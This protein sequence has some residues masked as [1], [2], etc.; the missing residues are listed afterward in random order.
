M[1]HQVDEACKAAIFPRARMRAILALAFASAFAV[2]W[3]CFTGVIGSD[4][5]GY[6]YAADLLAH[7]N[8]QPIAHHWTNRLM[9]ILPVALVYRLFGM[10]EWSTVITPL[11]AS[12]ASVPLL[13]AIGARLFSPAA[14]VIA[15]VLLMTFPVHVRYASV[16]VPEPVTEFLLLLGAWA[17]LRAGEQS[18]GWLY[19]AGVFFGLAYT[20]KEPAIFVGAA[21]VLYNLLRRRWKAA[22]WTVAGIST[23]IAVELSYFA[24]VTSDALF[25]FHALT[26]H[27]VDP[28]VTAA[29]A[30]LP[31]RLL[32]VYPRMML[33]PNVHF[34]VH[35]AA[36][37]LL[38]AAGLALMKRRGIALLLLLWAAIPWIYLNWGSSNLA[39]Y[40]AIPA[41]PRYIGLVYVPLFLAAAVA[42]ERAGLRRAMVWAP[43]AAVALSGIVM[44]RATR[45]TGYQTARVAELRTLAAKA[46]AAGAGICASSQ[47]QDHVLKTLGATVVTSQAPACVDP[48]Q[49]SYIGLR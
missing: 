32:K 20:G 28:A 48:G 47:V 7:G 10:Q 3:F 15:G 49:H 8:F 14:G 41:A 13:I 40:I 42:I 38:G 2:R 45:A 11:L 9:T 18:E 31:Y 22:A 23:V 39:R 26:V 4:D 46:R 17:Y 6:S 43:L 44:A 30:D 21:F 19:A 12:A 29:N 34:G 5:L 37:L 25:R 1:P 27:Y 24:A 16:L 35:S 36:V 33:I